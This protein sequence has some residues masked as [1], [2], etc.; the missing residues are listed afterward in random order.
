MNTQKKLYIPH[1]AIFLSLSK[2]NLYLYS[3][4]VSW[5]SF[6]IYNHTCIYTSLQNEERKLSSNS[7]WQIEF[8]KYLNHPPIF[9]DLSPEFIEIRT[10]SSTYQF[11]YARNSFLE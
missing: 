7:I 8:S 5:F 1:F 6:R 3:S 11:Y 2:S 9:S 10:E 4:S